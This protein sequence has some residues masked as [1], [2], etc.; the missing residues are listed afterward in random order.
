MKTVSRRA[1]GVVSRPAEARAA[2]RTTRAR[3]R[4]ARAPAARATAASASTSRCRP[5]RRT[6][7]GSRRT[8]C[9]SSR[10]AASRTTGTA[11][12]TRTSSC[13]TSAPPTTVVG[14][15]ST[16]A[17]LLRRTDRPAR[18]SSSP[19]SRSTH[20]PVALTT[21]AP[22][23]DV[24]P[25]TGIGAR[26]AAAPTSGA[27]RP[28]HGSPRRARRS[29]AARD[30]REAEPRVV[31]PGIRV[32][33]ARAQPLGGA[34]EPAL[35]PAPAATSQF[36]RE[37]ASAS[38]AGSAR[39][40]AGRNGPP[41]YSGSRNGMRWTRCGATT[42]EQRAPLVVR[43]ADEPHVA[44]PQVAQ[45]AVD[46]LRRR[47]RCRAAEVPAS[48]SATA[49]P[50]LAACAA[51]PAP[52]IPPPI[53]SRSN[54]RSPSRSSGAPRVMPTTGSSTP[55]AARRRS[56]RPGRG[57]APGASRAAHATIS[58]SR[59]LGDRRPVAVSEPSGVTAAPSDFPETRATAARAAAHLDR[60]V[61]APDTCMRGPREA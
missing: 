45:A 4:G 36:S 23:R 57:G 40:N 51:I 26:D 10:G 49:R 48:T 59:R 35:A 30:V 58:P 31:R 25:S 38:R 39:T 34:R 44:E 16:C 28:P 27:R 37:S 22:P 24:S 18:G 3:G 17:P 60:V 11:N 8:R 1:L 6:D 50:I 43:L 13:G 21:A 53:T 19:G 14:G 56:A 54:S 42:R 9:R 32:E 29:A 15:T 2:R 20:G 41:R 61:V 33:R 5:P 7:A 52:T 12:V 55:S 47:A 46:Q